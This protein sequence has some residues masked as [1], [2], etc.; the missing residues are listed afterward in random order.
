MKALDKSTGV[1]HTRCPV[2]SQHYLPVTFRVWLQYLLIMANVLGQ[3][4]TLRKT[5][6]VKK[7]L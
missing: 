3:W 5:K 1:F 7:G 6:C 2:E 4:I